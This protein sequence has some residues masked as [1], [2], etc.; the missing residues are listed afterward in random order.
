MKI[1]NINDFFVFFKKHKK[2]RK[3]DWSFQEEAVKK[4]VGSFKDNP[5]DK[6]LLVMPTGGGKT[7]AA[8]RAINNLIEKNFLSK[9]QKALWIVHTKALKDQV[10]RE[11]NKEE[12]KKNLK[13]HKDLSKILEVKMKTA[14][15]KILRLPLSQNYKLIIIDEAHHSAATTYSNFFRKNI[16]VLGLTATPTRNDEL[17]LDF[18]DIVYSITYREL[19]QRNV[20]LIPEFENIH[21]NIFVYAK[22]IKIQKNQEELEKFDTKER[23]I[24]ITKEIFKRR[25]KLKKILIFTGTINHARRL[26]EELDKENKILNCPYQH[27]GYIYGGDNNEKNIKN[28]DY[29]EE[30]KRYKKSILVNC[31][32]LN[33]GYDDPSINAI[34]MATPTSSILYYLQCVGRVVRNP[35]PKKYEK[36]YVL[37]VVDKLPN[38][39]Y[40]IDNRWLYADISD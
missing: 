29:L 28:N 9:E 14:A 34:V 1:K 37:E 25:E 30:H 8:I 10:E 23:N 11:I 15:N 38:I 4:I 13:F 17:E 31:K 7:I 26:Y 12:N 2:H 20:I 27:I 32:L 21:T 35:Y 22:S 18:N 40:R 39:N 3:P 16:G 5:K 33:E 6:T 19:Q 24:K 36:S